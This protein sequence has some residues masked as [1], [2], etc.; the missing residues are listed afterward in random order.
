MNER[1]VFWVGPGD[2]LQ[3]V[4]DLAPAGSTI[5]STGAHPGPIRMK[6]G[7]RIQG[8]SVQEYE[9]RKVG[10]GVRSLTDCVIT[11]RR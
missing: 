7:V 1:V 6:S 5:Y 9:E 2:D 11:L 3:A 10:L 8:V 4:I